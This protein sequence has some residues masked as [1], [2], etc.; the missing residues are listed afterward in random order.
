MCNE[1]FYDTY[2]AAYLNEKDKAEYDL[3]VNMKQTLTSK[4]TAENY[5][6]SVVGEGAGETVRKIVSDTVMK[7]AEHL[8]ELSDYVLVDFIISC[9]DG[10]DEEEYERLK[11]KAK[12]DAKCE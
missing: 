11:A 12:A 1:E 5:V 7:F 4:E 9:I 6:D 8:G 3:L 2:N 10:Y